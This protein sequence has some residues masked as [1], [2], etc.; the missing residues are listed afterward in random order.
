MNLAGL[1]QRSE[2]DTLDFKRENY[3]FRNATDEHKSEL[4]KDVLALANAWKATDAYILIG[5]AETNGRATAVPGVLPELNDSDLQQFVNSKTNRPIAFQVEHLEHEGSKLTVIRVLQKQSRPIFLNKN[6]GRLRRNTVYVRHGSSTDEASPDEIAE[7]V[8]GESAT[9]PD[10]ELRFQVTIDA[11]CYRP[12][13]RMPF[14]EDR[15]TYFDGFQIVAC[16]NGN[17]LARHIEGNVEL[18]RGVLFDHFRSLDV[19]SQS[20]FAAVQQSKLIKLEFSN[21]LREPTHSHLAKPN[22]L[23]WKPLL[24]GRELKLLSERTLPLRERFHEI[25]CVLKWELA[26]DNCDFRRGETRFSDIR[27]V[28]KGG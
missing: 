7:M 2:G 17:A 12:E 26:V 3:A 19:K 8:R 1:L 6:Y 25:G 9:S 20:P 22:P 21:H 23:E 15:T 27:I 18:P 11:Y 4:L 16:N 5:V 13:F 28:K 10:V 24:P 14:E